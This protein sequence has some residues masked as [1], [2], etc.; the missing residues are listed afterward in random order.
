MSDG[1]NFSQIKLE[2]VDQAYTSP[3]FSHLVQSKRSV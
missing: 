2:K 1:S 3:G